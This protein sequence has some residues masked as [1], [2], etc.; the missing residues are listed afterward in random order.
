MTVLLT[1]DGIEL[2]AGGQSKTESVANI[3]KMRFTEETAQ[4]DAKPH[5]EKSGPHA[6][7]SKSGA[8]SSSPRCSA[9]GDAR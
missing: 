4:T 3:V 1:R 8:A 7:N 5:S 9:A 2:A 6:E